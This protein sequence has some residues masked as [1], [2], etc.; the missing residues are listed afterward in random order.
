M[1]EREY[2]H[3]LLKSAPKYAFEKDRDC[4]NLF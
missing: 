4:S 3:Y 1:N 2:I